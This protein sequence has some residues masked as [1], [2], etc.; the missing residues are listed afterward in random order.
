[1][2]SCGGREKAVGK[3]LGGNLD[4][5]YYF[6]QFHFITFTCYCIIYLSKQLNCTDSLPVGS[7]SKQTLKCFATLPQI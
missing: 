2:L 4:Y 7:A 1:M 6:C 3:K 5:D